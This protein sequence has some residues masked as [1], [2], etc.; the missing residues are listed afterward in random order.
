MPSLD[1]VLNRRQ[2][3]ALT[4]ARAT[5]R[6]FAAALSTLPGTSLRFGPPRRSAASTESWIKDNTGSGNFIRLTAERPTKRNAALQADAPIRG[7]FDQMRVGIARSRFVAHLK[8]ARL[9]GLAYGCVIAPDDALLLDLSP[10]VEYP[11]SNGAF[12]TCH[13]A[14]ERL[15]LPQ[16]V[17]LPGR[18]LAI[19]TFGHGNFHH[20]LLDTL[21][22]FGEAIEAHFPLGD[23]DQIVLSQNQPR[24][25]R[26]SLEL[27]GVDPA[28]I[29]VQSE[30]THF[31][32]DELV[33]PSYSEPGRFP[34]QFDYTAEGL[35]F[36]RALFLDG[37]ISSPVQSERIVVSREK[38]K[39]RRV[40]DAIAFHA[41]LAA[42]GFVKVC[43]EDYSV[44]EQAAIF[45]QARIVVMPTGGGLANTVFC[46]PGTLIVEIFDPAYLPTFS[47]P[48]STAL[49]LRY[50]ALVGEKSTEAESH[51]DGG[52]MADIKI[53][54][55]RVLEAIRAVVSTFS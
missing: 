25:L 9:W 54:A 16:L 12:T 1:T 18:T 43:L 30:R 11:Y 17:H 8:H 2:N 36:V 52:S 4:A 10:S 29:Q 13:E 19:N 7:L 45:R 14:R 39:T 51:S 44:Q 34:E 42:E 24:F 48:L 33:V 46:D 47:L 38:T 40:L 6:L 15:R 23:F 26:E 21:P 31:L 35:Q 55:A 32:C 37:K 53:G 49:D 5:R 3:R 27:L 22:S 28:K 50:V 20:W 41:A